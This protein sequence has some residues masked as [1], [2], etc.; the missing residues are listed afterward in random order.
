MKVKQVEFSRLQ[1]FGTF[2]NVRVGCTVEIEDGESAHMALVRAQS[3]TQ[4]ELEKMV[5]KDALKFAGMA[6]REIQLDDEP[7]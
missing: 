1:S 4:R 3:W 2:N 5:G 7:F 6:Q